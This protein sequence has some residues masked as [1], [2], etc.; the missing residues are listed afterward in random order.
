MSPEIGEKLVG[1]YLKVIEK[2]DFISYNVRPPGGGR[3][4]LEELDVVGLK[5]ADKTAFLCEVT[6]HLRSMLYKDTM[7][8]R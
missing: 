4:G 7:R 3:R 5:F 6:T 8:R 1:A 2:C